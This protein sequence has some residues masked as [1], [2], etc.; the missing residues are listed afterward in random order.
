MVGKKL[1]HYEILAPL[2]AGGMGEV[3]RARDPRLDRIVAIK[4]LPAHLSE[5]A[6]ARARFEREARVISGLSHPNICTLHDVG[7]AD[8]A[9][10]LVMEYLEGETLAQRL[11]RERLPTDAALRIGS[12]IGSAL[13]RAHR[14]GV[15]HRDLKPG[16]VILTKDGAKLL[17]FGLAKTTDPLSEADVTGATRASE[18]LTER[19]TILGTFQ[20]MAPEQLEGRDVDARTD[21]FAFGALLYEMITGQKAFEAKSR[22]SLIAAILEREP[23]P[24]T[25]LEPLS[26]PAV[27]RV[28]R[29]CL[30]KDPDDRWQNAGDVASE[31]RWIADESSRAG[32]P[33][34][35]STRRRSRER[36]LWGLTAA[37]AVA[38]VAFGVTAWRARLGS[39]PAAVVRTLIAPPSEYA[40]E[41]DGI[42]PG[43]AA[44][45]PDGRRLVFAAYERHRKVMLWVR[46]LDALEPRAL[47]G[48]EDARY[49]FW[50]PDGREVAFFT[51]DK[52]KRIEVAGGP[53][54]PICDA[55]NGKGGSWGRDGTIVFAPS[56]DT[57]LS[58]VS[59]GGGEVTP[60][61]ALDS[62]R[63]EDS[64]RL[65]CFLP[66]G[67]R[68]LYYARG[69]SLVDGARTGTIV[70]GSLDGD[71]PRELFP[72][73]S[74]AV[75][76]D[77]QV[78]FVRESTLFARRLDGDELGDAVPLAEQVQKV[79]N[80]MLGAFSAVRDRLV[81]HQAEGV[82][83][84][85]IDCVD[86]A[87][88]EIAT[89]G[90]PGPFSDVRLSPDGTQ[91]ALTSADFDIWLADM[92]TGVRTRFTLDPA[93]ETSP[94]WSPDGS[95]ILF[96][97]SRDGGIL[98]L[99]R[100]SVEGTGAEELVLAT[101]ENK[102]PSS[103]SPDGKHVLFDAGQ[104]IWVLPLD[105][106]EP[107]RFATNGEAGRFSPDGRWVLYA[108]NRPGRTGVIV[109]P[110]PATGREYQIWPGLAVGWWR[111]GRSIVCDDRASD[112]A[113][114]VDVVTDGETLRVGASRT[115]FPWPGDVIFTVARG[116]RFVFL[117]SPSALESKPLVLVQNWQ[118]LL[119]K[120]RGGAG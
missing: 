37:L 84:A 9:F 117:R 61:T 119:R 87:G 38:C 75:W 31:L 89:V 94:V 41:L 25:E 86:A 73:E 27:D 116:D 112:S 48:T 113:I 71:P 81:Y 14:A 96:A 39:P 120:G 24:I 5:R 76:V 92:G 66:D 35:V 60:I 21:I 83:L 80:A 20:Y 44:L 1:G 104:E 23:R 67:R 107:F 54:Y 105:G 109:S 22:A 33:R 78:L 17:D 101:P 65:P 15:I 36:I 28:V 97:S 98:N 34:V 53:V 4:I 100:K 74:Q 46:D 16:N 45:S 88:K 47:V 118:A 68:F 42:A 40:F 70:L 63:T 59:A 32:V 43:P 8:G 64:H 95:T 85:Q 52:L 56:W 91:L 13:Q 51:N 79:D 58:R 30:A 19:G 49:P 11:A 18:P 77:G 12:E 6:D 106:G 99:Y 55:R 108:S 90:E 103:W 3:Y 7:E 2:G 10:F 114:E 29:R 72:S 115:L 62:T 26:P 111:G 102:W 110:F 50:S 69:L 82:A 57:G 93:V